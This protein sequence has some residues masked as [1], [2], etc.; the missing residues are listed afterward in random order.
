MNIRNADE[1]NID[2]FL[3]KE[4]QEKGI[5]NLISQSRQEFLGKN[6]R[7]LN[8]SNRRGEFHYN[9]IKIQDHLGMA[10][11]KRRL[12]I[13]AVLKKCKSKFF[14]TVH[15]VLKICLRCQVERLPQKF[16]TD[17][18]I[19]TNKKFMPM[20]ILSIYQNFGFF[21]NMEKLFDNNTV[22]PDK[23]SLLREFLSQNFKFLFETYLQSEHYQR[24]Y[25]FTC[26]EN[27]NLAILFYYTCK[28][29][30]QY[31]TTSKGNN[32]HRRRKKS[33]NKGSY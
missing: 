13:D 6:Q 1:I 27:E 29:F 15:S 19:E 9:F 4:N 24:D 12:Q 11:N 20:T 8:F 30:T 32:L 2:V 14:K 28:I 5:E 25:Y 16:I 18:R 22:R 26:E 7:N 23:K 10:N 31:Y 17:I 3:E 33:S 21:R